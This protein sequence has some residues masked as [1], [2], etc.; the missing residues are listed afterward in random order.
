MGAP[1]RSA[2][3]EKKDEPRDFVKFT[4]FHLQPGCGGVFRPMRAKRGAPPLPEK[5]YP[6]PRWPLPTDLLNG[7]SLVGLKAGAEMMVWAIGPELAPI[8]ESHSR[9]LGTPLG[10]YLQEPRKLVPR[11]RPSVRV[12]RSACARR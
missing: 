10:G 1:E 12:S 4:F 2:E 8:Q 6:P 11:N 7:W 5:F 9:L 3:V